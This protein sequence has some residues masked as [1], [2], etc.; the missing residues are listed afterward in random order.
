MDMDTMNECQPVQSFD[1]SVVQFDVQNGDSE[2]NLKTVLGY[3]DI[4]KDSAVSLVVLPEMFSCGFDNEHLVRHASDSGRILERLCRAAEDTGTAIAGSLP[5][6]SGKQVFNAFYFIDKDGRISGSY[7]KIHLFRPT[8][9]HLYFKADNEIVVLDT[10]LGKIGLAVCYDLRFPELFVQFMDRGAQAVLVCAQWPEPRIRHW[11]VLAQA[12]AIENQFFMICANRT[13]KDKDLV[14]NGCSM[15]VDPQGRVLA[16]ASTKAGYTQA[17]ID[18]KAMENFR[19]TMPF[20][21]D[22]RPGIYGQ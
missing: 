8:Q 5:E 21:K 19:T 18:L 9:E 4:L 12:R 3:I 15:I 6:L 1:A 16:D 22:R 14:F 11:Q 20:L 7:R 10:S 17:E 2:A 13:G